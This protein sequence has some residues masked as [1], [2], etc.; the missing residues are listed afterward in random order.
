MDSANRTIANHSSYATNPRCRDCHDGG[1]LHNNTLY[2]SPLSLPNSTYCLS[3]HGTPGSGN[4]TI[5]NLERH[6]GTGTQCT[7]CHLNSSAGIH[8]VR[9]LQQDNSWSSSSVNAVNCSS[10]HQGTGLSGFGSAPKVPVI[11][12]S[13]NEYSGALWNGTQARFWDNRSQQSSCEY[14]H[15]IFTMHNASG[16]GNITKVKGTN[17]VRQNLSG[18]S[19]CANCHY[20]AAANYSGNMF[21]PQPPEVKNSSGLVPAV[22]NDG[23]LFYNHSADLASGYDDAKCRTCHDNSLGA[24]ATSS[25]FTHSLGTGGGGP[26]CISCHGTGGSLAD[27]KRINQSAMN[28]SDAVHKDLNRNTAISDANLSENRKCWACHGDGNEPSGHPARYKTPF[29]CIECH[30]D[31]QISSYSPNNT[32]L[33]VIQHYWNGTS[34]TTSSATSCYICH[35]RSEMMTGLNPDPDGAGTVGAGNGGNGSVSHYGKKRSDMASLD[36]TSYCNYCHNNISSVFPF[37]NATNNKT[38]P[39]HSVN[40]PSTNPGCSACHASGRLHSSALVKPAFS[41][42]NGSFCLSC[43]GRNDGGGTNYTGAVTGQKE[44]HNDSLCTECHINSTKSIHQ[45]RYLRQNGTWATSNTSPV[46]CTSCHQ[47][48]GMSGFAAAAIIQTPLWHSNDTYSG[49][50]WNGTQARYWDNRSQQSSCDYC[51]GKEAIHNSSGLGK[52]TLIQGTNLKNQ[53]LGGS[54]WCANC[55]YKGA[56][57]SGKYNYK[58]EPA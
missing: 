42:T 39:N 23:I 51:H 52:S 6:N 2:M 34:I 56:V 33:S 48:Q 19:W 5:K 29:S 57:P 20:G 31:G 4:T 12:H 36:N 44:K 58:G 14:C 15:G 10:C 27:G 24:A 50:L 55:H 11:A 26:D 9:Y 1:R 22:A 46:N 30:V 17:N 16:L 21:I 45:V 37:A 25:N 18:G 13:T 43:H 49:A 53:S 28:R 40:Y 7:Q 8:P 3:C 35:N 54:F 32:I 41:I 38:I 47:G